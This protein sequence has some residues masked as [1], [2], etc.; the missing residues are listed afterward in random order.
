VANRFSSIGFPIESRREL[1]SLAERLLPKCEEHRTRFGKYLRYASPCG[2]EL[3]FQ[4]GPDEEL[5]GATPCFAASTP[6]RV[7]LRAAVERPDDTPLE[8]ALQARAIARA[9]G[10]DGS[11]ALPLVF[12][13]PDY[14]AYGE[15][16]FPTTVEARIAAFARRLACHR[17]FEELRASQALETGLASRSFVP[18]G[19]FSSDGRK[20]HPPR[21]EVVFAGRVRSSDRRTN[22]ATGREFLAAV[23]ECSGAAFHVVADVELV[24]QLVA[25][26]DVLSGSFWLCGRPVAPPPTRSRSARGLLRRLFRR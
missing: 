1:D 24:P 15:I 22:Q 19:L 12:D 6:L 4:V 25:V 7:E 26:D 8:G 10:T 11:G 2:A 14:R 20:I 3:W 16:A 13:C 5:L 9:G 17:S 18:S 21:S 23:V